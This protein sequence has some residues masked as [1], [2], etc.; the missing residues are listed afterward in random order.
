MR[1]WVGRDADADT[2]TYAD[3]DA[4]PYT[5]ADADTDAN[6]DANAYTY[7]HAYTYTDSHA[8]TDPD[9]HADAGQSV[10]IQSDGERDVR[11]AVGRDALQREWRQQGHRHVEQR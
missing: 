4:N 6:P 9:P 7:T 11:G 5:H 10:A 2:G 3:T 1:R 8:Y